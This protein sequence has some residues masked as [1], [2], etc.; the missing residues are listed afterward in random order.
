M[1]A[2]RRIQ[3]L[4]AARLAGEAV[5]SI[6]ARFQVSPS[7]V[8][9]AFRRELGGTPLP[10]PAN[11]NN[12]HRKT[13]MVARLG[14]CSTTSGKM[15]VTLPRIPTLDREPVAPSAR[16]IALGYEVAA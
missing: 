3:E 8:Y 1:S 4:R 9:Q 10:G 2:T 11:D 6:S 15:P 12:P 7:A 5:K 16:E 14:C 13:A